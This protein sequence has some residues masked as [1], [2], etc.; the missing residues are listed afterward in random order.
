MFGK[1]AA[2]LFTESQTGSELQLQA[3]RSVS[4]QV[5]P[6]FCDSET[7]EAVVEACVLLAQWT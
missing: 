5:G 2:A 1:A 3:I 6:V 7:L 4:I